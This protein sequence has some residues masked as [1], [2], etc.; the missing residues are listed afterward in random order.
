MEQEL[1]KTL[2]LNLVYVSIYHYF[3]FLHWFTLLTLNMFYKLLWVYY[4]LSAKWI[5]DCR[6][7]FRNV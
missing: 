4:Q 7:R 3:F 6:K 1:L 2:I 5:C